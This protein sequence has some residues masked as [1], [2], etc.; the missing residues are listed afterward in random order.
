M[1]TELGLETCTQ[2]RQKKKRTRVSVPLT[3]PLFYLNHRRETKPKQTEAEVAIWTQDVLQDFK[4]FPAATKQDWER[5]H[6]VAVK[7]AEL[8]R[9]R[10]DHASAAA[11]AS[12]SSQVAPLSLHL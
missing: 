7:A 8:E 6:A 3:A 4:N 11:S 12:P 1:M 2:A 5:R 9:H 10:L